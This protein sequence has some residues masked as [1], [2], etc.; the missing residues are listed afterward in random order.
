MSKKI[1]VIVIAVVVCALIV[2][3]IWLY[4]IFSEPAAPQNKVKLPG[5]DSVSSYTYNGNISSNNIQNC[6]SPMALELKKIYVNEGDLVKKGDPLFLLDDSDVTAALS[7]AQAG[8]QLAQVNLEKAQ[9]AAD[10]VSLVAAKSAYDAAQ[11]A[12]TEA[13]NTLDRI[14]TLQP[15]GGISQSDYEKAQNA[16]VTAEGQ[17]N[18]AKANY[19]TFGQQ[20]SQNVRAAQAQLAQARANYQ[21]AQVSETKRRVT[22]NFDGMVADIWAYENNDLVPGQKILDIVDYNSLIL[23]ITVDQFEISHFKLS[24]SVPVY[25]NSLNATFNGTVSKISNQAIKTGDV[26][27]FIVTIDLDKDPALK[28]GLLAEVRKNV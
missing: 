11:A 21:A 15:L 9:L 22:A 25:I 23:E 5:D 1:T 17:F 4:V 10:T 12:Y 2:L 28:V 7:Q 16:V 8:I 26:S 24:E 14:S 3:G 18:Q 6:V 13:K 27:S 20:S 19:E